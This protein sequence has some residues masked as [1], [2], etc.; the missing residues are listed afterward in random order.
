MKQLLALLAVP[1]LLQTPVAPSRPALDAFLDARVAAGDAPAIVAMAVGLD[2][3]LYVGA[4][5]KASVAANRPVAADS[6]FRI[7]SMTKPIT[8][9]A[10][11]MLWEEGRLR[12]DDPVTKYLP[13]FARLRVITGPLDGSGRYGSRPPSRPVTVRDLLTH[14]SGMAYSFVDARLKKLD[15][16][17]RTELELPLLADPGRKFMYGPSTAVVGQI[18][19]KISGQSLDAFF[20]SRIF[21]PLGMH[22]TF[23]A[24][25]ADKRDRVVTTHSRRPDGSLAETPNPATL[26]APPRGDGGLFSTAADY[27]RF[28]Q[29]I[30]N[31]GRLGT[32]RLLREQTVTMM[33]ANQIGVLTVEEQPSLSPEFL[34]PFPIGAGKDKFG[35][36]FQIEQPPASPGLRSAGSLSWGGVYNTHF[37]IDPQRSMAAVVLMQL[38]PYYDPRAMAVARGF[39]RLVYGRVR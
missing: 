22:D 7:A 35:F 27:A 33:A 30:L 18:V 21:D 25:P 20:K 15:D 14:T 34:R 13:E 4:F 32:V 8:S 3:S 2:S 28:M 17:R 19:E 6:I 39:E 5:G 1:L 29:M 23:F 38:L 37:W 12:L 11:M 9:V 36:G 10:A 16:A 26:Q 24:V 31:R